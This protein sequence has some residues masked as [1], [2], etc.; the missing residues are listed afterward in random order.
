VV[1]GDDKAQVAWLGSML[2]QAG[3]R[4]DV[5]HELAAFSAANLI[6]EPPAAV[7]MD[8]MFPEGP[9]GLRAWHVVHWE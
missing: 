7:I 6:S 9:R 4:V 8:M 1:V 2:E 5:F 3:Y